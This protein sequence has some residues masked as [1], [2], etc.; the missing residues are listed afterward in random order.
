[1]NKKEPKKEKPP[2][3]RLAGKEKK[4]RSE[5]YIMKKNSGLK[6]ARIVFWGMLIF[7]FVRGV[8]LIF[9][10][11]DSEQVRQTIENF[12][13]E[14][15]S[16]KD[17]NEE[18]LGFAENFAKEYLTYEVKGESD[19]KKRLEPYVSSQILSLGDIVDMKENARVT[20]ARAYRKEEYAPNR[21]D[22]YV[23][24]EVEYLSGE[25]TE[26][27]PAVPVPAV[28]EEAGTDPPPEELQE[29][30]SQ[31]ELTAPVITPPVQ[32]SVTVGTQEQGETI[33][34][35]YRQTTLKVPVFRTEEGA[36]VIESLP[37]FVVDARKDEA[38]SAKEYQ[39]TGVAEAVTKEIQTSLG[40]FLGAY[41]EQDQSVIDYYLD[42]NADKE[43]FR[44]LQGRFRL[45][46]I[47]NLKCYQ[48]EGA[49]IIC[50]VT[51]RIRDSMNEAVLRQ[52]M[53]ITVRKDGSQYYVLD[54]N[55][56]TGNLK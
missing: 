51:F 32:P 6:A 24:A 40:N 18:V 15:G 56:R 38:Y 30:E 35:I 14:F 1:M 21:F 50:I 29:E 43:K 13:Q 11:D 34:K 25:Q 55:V 49:D 28:S 23:L 52:Q 8:L 9:R 31:Q 16:Y 5:E 7:F 37:A 48:E 54:M 3:Q 19:Y 12:R 26:K 45:V 36:Y 33:V 42:K 39:G 20:Y 4:A 17:A 46:Q 41:Y 47:D 10:P 53:N 44:S 2:K 22:V 27:A